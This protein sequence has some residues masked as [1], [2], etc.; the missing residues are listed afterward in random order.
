MAGFGWSHLVLAAL[1]WAWFDSLVWNLL[2]WNWLGSVRLD[3]VWLGS[4]ELGIDGFGPA[5]LGFR[6]GSAKM[7]CN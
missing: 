1:G 2:G 5:A 4:T 6:M 3:R 7:G